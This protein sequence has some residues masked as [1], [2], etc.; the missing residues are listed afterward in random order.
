ML[1][2]MAISFQ[3]EKQNHLNFKSDLISFYVPLP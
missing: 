2:G 1:Y 3:I